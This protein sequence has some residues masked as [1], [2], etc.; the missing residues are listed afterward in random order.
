[1]KKQG[2]DR[3]LRQ[4]EFPTITEDEEEVV[5]TLYAL[6]VGMFTNNDGDDD[7]CTLDAESVEA[8]ASTSPKSKERQLAAAEGIQVFITLMLPVFNKY[9][10]KFA[11]CSELCSW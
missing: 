9:F 1:M 2:I 10:F 5:K 11:R 8:N 4:T 6:A 3:S 7:K